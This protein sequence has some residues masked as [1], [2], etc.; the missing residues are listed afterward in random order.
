[1]VNKD[2]YKI[3]TY[4]IVVVLTTVIL[5]VNFNSAEVDAQQVPYINIGNNTNMS[6]DT[7]FQLDDSIANIKNLVNGTKLEIDN[8]NITAA[9]NLLNKIYEQLIQVSANSNNLIWDLSNKGN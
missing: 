6:D 9:H 8:G 5:F 2:N 4:S 1:M 3:L 7:F